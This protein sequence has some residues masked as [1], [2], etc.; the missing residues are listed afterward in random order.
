MGLTVH[1]ADHFNNPV[2]D[3]TAVYFTTEGGQIQ[4]QCEILDGACS[5]N[6]TSSNPR[7]SEGRI[8]I[9]ASMLGE[10]SFIDANGNGVLD[11]GDT[12][13]ANIP[14]AFRD[15]DENGVR[16]PVLEEFVDFNA[17]GVYD[18]SSVDPNYNGAL[19]C[20]TSAVTEAEQAVAAGEDPG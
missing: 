15:D 20:D 10:E 9:L 12:A 17:N 7:S 1:A 18:D 19:C 16:D 8:T 11:F 2:P 4:S 6:W 14:E 5:V 13:F 3:G